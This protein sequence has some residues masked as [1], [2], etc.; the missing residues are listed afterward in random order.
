MAFLKFGMLAVAL[1]LTASFA[2]AQVTVENAWSRPA[3]AGSTGVGFMVLANGGAK[4]DALIGAVS[5]AARRIE[6]HRSSMEHGVA[7]MAPVAR[8]PLAPGAAVAFAPGGYHLMLLDL[9]RPLKVGDT[10]PVTLTLASGVRLR[11][12]FAVALAAPG[13]RPP[14][15]A[16]S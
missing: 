11:A 10:V 12:K 2:Q 8:V 1:A 3:V 5:P 4:A 7:M 16:G 14:R 6:I 13:K 15:L 9:T